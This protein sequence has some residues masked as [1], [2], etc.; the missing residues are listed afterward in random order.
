MYGTSESV[1]RENTDFSNLLLGKHHHVVMLCNYGA[2]AYNQLAINP[3][4]R[5]I[6]SLGSWPVSIIAFQDL[7]FTSVPTW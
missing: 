5:K 2:T 4:V 6:P 3:K 1:N 7:H